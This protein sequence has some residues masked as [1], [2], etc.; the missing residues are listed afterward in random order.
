MDLQKEYR[1]RLVTRIKDVGRDL[2]EMADNMVGED[3]KYIKDFTIY[4]TFEEGTLVPS[5]DWTMTVHS[6]NFYNKLFD[7][8]E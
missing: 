3:I 7:K 6:Q 2:V 8:G 1:D 5:I 4:I